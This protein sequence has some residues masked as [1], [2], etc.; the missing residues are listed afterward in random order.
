MAGARAGKDSRI[1]APTVC[2]EAVFGGHEKHLSKGE[3]AMIPLV[4]QDRRAAKIAFGYIRGYFE[5][6]ALLSAL[7]D[8][9]TASE[10]RL[11]NVNA[12]AHGGK[13]TAP[14]RRTGPPSNVRRRWIPLSVSR[15]VS[16][17]KRGP[18]R[19]ETDTTLRGSERLVHVAHS[20]TRHGRS[21]I[22]LRV[23]D[24]DAL[25]GKQQARDGRRVL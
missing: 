15:R 12:C 5:S 8:D 18:A 1:A 6:S 9:V 4:A 22:L 2:F 16:A 24:D 11:T 7:I 25:G 14:I 13:K 3:R 21:S 17:A 23:V 20:A 10:I 19:E